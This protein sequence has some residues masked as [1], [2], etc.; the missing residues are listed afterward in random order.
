MSNAKRNFVNIY[1]YTDDGVSG[2]T[3]DRERFQKM[4]KAV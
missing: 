2:T 3:F 1:H 4:I